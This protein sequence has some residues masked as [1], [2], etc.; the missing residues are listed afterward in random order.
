M[1]ENSV[2]RIVFKTETLANIHRVIFPLLDNLPEGL[3]DLSLS[4]LPEVNPRVLDKIAQK[5]CNLRSLELHCTERLDTSCCWDCFEESASCIWHS[6]IPDLFFDPR[7]LSV[8][9]SSYMRI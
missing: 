4:D 6:P 3:T 5:F 9:M 2:V 8:S 1:I 7:D